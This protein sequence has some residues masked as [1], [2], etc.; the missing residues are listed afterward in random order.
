M[1]LVN[2][3]WHEPPGCISLQQDSPVNEWAAGLASEHPRQ[4]LFLP[5]TLPAQPP[6]GSAVAA[7]AQHTPASPVS[8]HRLQRRPGA[9]TQHAQPFHLEITSPK[10]HLLF[11][12][13]EYFFMIL[14]YLSC[15]FI[16]SDSV[17]KYLWWSYIYNKFITVYL[18]VIF[19][20]F[21]YSVYFH[22]SP[23]DLY[24]TDIR[25]FSMCHKQN[26]LLL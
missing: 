25:H 12:F 18:Q 5:A 3:C 23:P 15:W 22:F 14:F 4:C 26:N 17:F 19:Y 13:I 16:S 7:T 20:Y 1:A 21:T 2:S 6:Q 10:Y 11:S 24:A 9:M 8:H